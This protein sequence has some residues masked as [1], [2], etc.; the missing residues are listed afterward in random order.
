MLGGYAKATG[1]D[2]GDWHKISETQH[3]RV[4]KN[5]SS[6]TE[7]G[8][9]Q[10]SD[11]I[12]ADADNHKRLCAVCG[13][14]QIESHL[15]GSVSYSWTKEGDDWKATASRTCTECG[16][17]QAETVTAAGVQSKAPTCTVNGETTYTAAF[18]NTAFETKTKT[19]ADIPA[20]SHD[21]KTEW[22]KDGVNHWHDCTRCD[23]KNAEAAHTYGAASYTWEQTAG[24]W[25]A[26]A[27][28]ACTVC[29]WEDSETVTATGAQ[30]KA[31]AC[32][33][34][35]ETTYT[36]TFSNPAFTTQVKTVA[37]V[38]SLGHAYNAVVTPP[39]CTE[40][41]YTTHTCSRCSD[42]YTDSQ[43]PAPGHTQSKAVRE[44]EVPAACEKD[45]SYDEVV[46]CAVCGKELSRK[47]VTVPATGHEDA[48]N[49]GKCDRCGKQMQGGDHCKLCGKSHDK[50]TFRGVVKS[51]LHTLV[52][53]A[54]MYVVP[55]LGILWY[56][57]LSMLLP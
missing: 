36:A 28:R 23:E 40:D 7:T 45:G 16:R 22:S 34:N 37:D 29:G 55:V 15:Y 9:H 3:Q 48:D 1:H 33:V 38:A 19:L 53:Y 27:K 20:L 39:T 30:S 42:T 56:S 51:W 4:C 52:Y 8:V 21:W 50:Q 43:T 26:T 2:W 32:T 18:S 13:T 10:W 31:P 25:K 11:W 46:Y 54:K 5:D 24:A 57:F 12:F 44:N 41:G 14:A 49:D 35:G 6:H 17:E 47:S